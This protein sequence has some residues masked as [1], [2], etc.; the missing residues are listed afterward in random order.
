MIFWTLFIRDLLLAKKVLW[1]VRMIILTTTAS[2]TTTGSKSVRHNS[3]RW[4]EEEEPS[5][6]I[7]VYCQSRGSGAERIWCGRYQYPPWAISWSTEKGKRRSVSGIV[8]QSL[9]RCIECV[10]NW[11]A[12]GWTTSRI[13]NQTV[14]LATRCF[15]RDSKCHTCGTFRFLNGWVMMVVVDSSTDG[16]QKLMVSLGDKTIRRCHLRL[17]LLV[18]SLQYLVGRGWT[19]DN[20]EEGTKVSCDGHCWFFHAFTTCGAKFL[21][22][23]FVQIPQSAADLQNC[24][25]ENAFAGFP[26]CIGSTNATHIPLDKVTAAIRQ[27]HIGYKMGSDATTRTY[28]LTVNHRRQILN[29]TTGHPGRWNDKAVVRFDSFRAAHAMVHMMSWWILFLKDR[30]RSKLLWI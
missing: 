8:T 7:D 15:G 6:I 5:C 1:W 20:I 21:Y 18:C 12:G 27:A 30:K 19:C 13:Q 4:E 14:L 26:G 9:E 10:C 22:P 2:L 28:N 29:S 3:G 11:A 17:L 16:G 25:S 24:V 23:R